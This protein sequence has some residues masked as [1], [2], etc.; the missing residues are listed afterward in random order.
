MNKL[1]MGVGLGVVSLAAAKGGALFFVGAGVTTTVVARKATGSNRRPGEAVEFVKNA[2]IQARM[3]KLGASSCS[4]S[5]LVKFQLMFESYD[6]YVDEVKAFLTL[7]H[8]CNQ[9]DGILP[10]NDEGA[11]D[12]P[13]IMDVFWS[14]GA[15]G[16]MRVH[17]SLMLVY[18]GK[19]QG[20]FVGFKIEQMFLGFSLH[21]LT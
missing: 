8:K 6:Q 11:F 9:T 13:T 3:G 18:A 20:T 15:H 12:V 14:Y 19:T 2:A 17:T 1:G 4:S 10:T 16:H 7:F 5:S 21:K